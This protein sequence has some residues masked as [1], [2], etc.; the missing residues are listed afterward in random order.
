MKISL[1]DSKFH[2]DFKPIFSE[3]GTEESTPDEFRKMK[4]NPKK[5][6]TYIK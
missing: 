4:S 1:K 5:G 6:P 2:D 3:I